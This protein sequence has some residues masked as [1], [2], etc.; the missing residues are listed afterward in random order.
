MT[1]KMTL[2]ELVEISSASL[3]P[4]IAVLTAYIAW[5]Q[6]QVSHSMLKKDLYERRLVVYKF[7]MSYLADIIRDGAVDYQRANQ[8]YAEASEADFLFDDRILSKLKELYHEGLR[9]AYLQKKIFIPV[10]SSRLSPDE[11]DKLVDE[12]SSL[13]AWFGEQPEQTKELFMK[14]MKLR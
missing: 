1:L 8:F 9:L 2:K 13:V 14:Q 7:V 5:R 6:Y 10:N 4:L 12:E 3:T 11:R